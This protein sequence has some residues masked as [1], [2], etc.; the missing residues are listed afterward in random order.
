MTASSGNVGVVIV[1][2]N[3]QEVLP[4]CVKSLFSQDEAVSKIII[5]DSGSSDQSYLKAF[6]NNPLVKVIYKKNI[7]FAAANNLGAAIL[8]PFCEVIL[9]L[10]PDVILENIFIST[11][12]SLAR[13]NPGVGILTGKM[14]R[15]DLP[16]NKVTTTLDSTGIFRKW[17][18][19]W[20]D[21]GQ[22]EEDN[23]QYEKAQFIPAIC[24]ALMFCNCH[25]LEKTGGQ[26]KEIFD[27]EFFMYKE[28]ID[29]SLRIRKRGAKL[30]YSPDLLAH[31]CR[32]WQK[33]RKKVPYT[34]RLMSARNEMLLY[35]KHPSPYYAWALFKYV[36]VR[37]FKL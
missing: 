8:I 32:G 24:G 26:A 25:H 4:K 37:F 14:L 1:A 20:C 31:H 9:F 16:E 28:D 7:G 11:A 5:V 3:S 13:Q 29:L 21:R 30:L 23:G 34:F 19:R 15:F 10:N 35:N 6:D 22:G 33:Q 12:H 17:Y 36:L 2:H 27:P 18:G